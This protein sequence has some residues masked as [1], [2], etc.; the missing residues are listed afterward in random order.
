MNISDML[1]N[2]HRATY[3][4][5]FCIMN[6]RICWICCVRKFFCF[7]RRIYLFYRLHNLSIFKKKIFEQVD[8]ME[9]T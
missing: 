3:L 7:I 2:E 4:F 8:I 9:K 5:N 6:K 1:H